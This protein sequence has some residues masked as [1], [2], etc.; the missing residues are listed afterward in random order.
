MG[1][2][3]FGFGFTGLY[4]LVRPQL[5]DLPAVRDADP[6]AFDVTASPD[7]DNQ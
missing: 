7:R 6:A 3:A 4:V 1:P 2:A 5:R